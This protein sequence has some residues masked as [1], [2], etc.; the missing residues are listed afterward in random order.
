MD[1]SLNR[2]R[3]DPQGA[4]SYMTRD[5][6]GEQIAVT[7]SHAYLQPDGITFAPVTP[8]GRWWCQ[9]GEHAIHDPT[10]QNP[11]NITKFETFEITGIPGHSGV[12]FHWG[13][14]PKTQS[15]GCEL[16]GSAFATINDAEE[17]LNSRVTFAA[18]MQLQDGVDG[19]WLTVQ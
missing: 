7:G 16:M 4:F 13:N 11:N 12:L 18:F 3:V 14:I 1:M 19:F 15:D 6:T 5:D 17:V 10:P 2:F 8:P 9:R